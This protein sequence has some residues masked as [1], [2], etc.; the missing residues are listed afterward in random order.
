MIFKLLLILALITFSFAIPKRL[1]NLNEIQPFIVNGTDAKIEEFP[2][3]VSLLYIYQEDY[4]HA[5]GG[6]ILNEDW[7]LTVMKKESSNIYHTMKCLLCHPKGCALY[8]RR[9]TR[10]LRCSILINKFAFDDF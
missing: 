8:L 1:R 6:S 7:V 9:R 2:F 3:I 10:I 4:S 5:C